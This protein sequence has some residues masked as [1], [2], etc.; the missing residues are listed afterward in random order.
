MA[1]LTLLVD[2]PGATLKRE[3]ERLVVRY[4][5]GV[6]ERVGAKAIAQIFV[7][8]AVQVDTSVLRLAA[9]QSISLTALPGR[10]GDTP[11][12]LVPVQAR[13]SERRLRQYACVLSKLTRLTVARL[14]VGAK[15]ES[16]AT[17]LALHG[18]KLDQILSRDAAAKAKSVGRLLGVEGAASAKY[19][20]QLRTIWPAQWGFDGRNRRPPRDPVNAMMSLAYTLALQTAIRRILHY[21]R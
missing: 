3:G 18:V 6:T 8:S 14:V 16:Q 4:A 9:Q 2:K 12:H 7:G 1:N 5:D 20:A 17:Y 13:A 10:S 19:F 21:G 11:C 15:L